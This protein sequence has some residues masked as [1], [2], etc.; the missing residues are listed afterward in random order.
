MATESQRRRPGGSRTE[1]LLE[2]EQIIAAALRLTRRLGLDNMSMRKLGDELGVTSMALYWYFKS[3]DEL[4]DAVTDAVLQQVELPDAGDK[5]W[6]EH[7]RFIAWAVHDVLVEYPGIADQLLTYQ[8]FPPSAIPVVDVSVR[9]LRDAGFNE[10]VAASAFNVLTSYVVTRSHFEA[11]QRLV[12]ASDEAG[13]DVTERAVQGWQRLG[14]AV[15][16]AEGARAYVDH[17]GDLGTPEAVFAHGLDLLLRGL[18][19]ELDS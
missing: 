4:V 18:R 9:T 14:P 10:L 16:G 1:P 12:T 8:N 5:P 11:Y 2:R 3:K 19:D 7:L 13:R 15:G 17:L 6:D